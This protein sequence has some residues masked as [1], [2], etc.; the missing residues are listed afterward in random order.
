MV[1]TCLV[2]YDKVDVYSCAVASYSPEFANQSKEMYNRLVS[3]TVYTSDD[4]STNLVVDVDGT[5]VKVK[6]EAAS[7]MV[8]CDAETGIRIT[9]PL[10]KTERKRSMRAQLAGRLAE[11]LQIHDLRGEKQLYRIINELET[12]TDDI[13]DEENI[14]RVTWLPETSR[15]PPEEGSEDSSE[16]SKDEEDLPVNEAAPAHESR[17]LS[18]GEE[19]TPANNP[20][21]ARDTSSQGQQRSANSRPST[22]DPF[23]DTPAVAEL[24]TQMFAQRVIEIRQF[25]STVPA[26]DD[27]PLHYAEEVLPPPPPYR[28]LPEAFNHQVEAPDYWKVLEHARKQ[29]QS[30]GSGVRELS[31]AA[32]DDVANLFDGLHLGNT[33]LEAT[34][35]QYLFG[36]DVWTSRFRVGAAGELFVGLMQY[37]LDYN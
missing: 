35:Y 1:C 25:A 32:N 34:A 17:E 7:L 16:T 18:E 6:S 12:G 20:E 21:T 5:R 9:L 23:V 27:V 3:A 10:N 15:P 19:Q 2:P 22:D 31:D 4:M 24:T 36:K 26:A 8:D 29:G 11:L 14:S 13:M 28:A 30:L 37:L 33:R